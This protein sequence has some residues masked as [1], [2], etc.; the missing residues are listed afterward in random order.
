MDN[1]NLYYMWDKMKEFVP[2]RDKDEACYT[3]LT[4][5]AD[6]DEDAILTIKAIALD[7]GDNEFVKKVNEIIKEYD[8][9]EYGEEW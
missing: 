7:E 2:Q 6:E 5:I 8:I 4:F 1:D 9:E 3:F